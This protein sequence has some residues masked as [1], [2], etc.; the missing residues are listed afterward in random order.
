MVCSFYSPCPSVNQ[1]SMLWV[2]KATY[3]VQLHGKERG[4]KNDLWSHE[5]IK[6]KTSHT[7]GSELTNCVTLSSLKFPLA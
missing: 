6:I 7:E 1:C 2:F 3:N 4:E 5:G